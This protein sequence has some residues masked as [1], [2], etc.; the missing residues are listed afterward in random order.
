M[1]TISVPHSAQYK[2]TT[3]NESHYEACRLFTTDVS[4]KFQVM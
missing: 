2:T 3:L 1:Y 4:A